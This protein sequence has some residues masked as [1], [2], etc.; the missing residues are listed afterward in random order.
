MAGRGGLLAALLTVGSLSDFV[1]RR[2]IIVA[3]LVI[4]AGAMLLI[5]TAQAPTTLILAR[6]L[7]GIA[8]GAAASTLGAMIM[9][10]CKVRGALINSAAPPLGPE[11]PLSIHA[12]GQPSGMPSS[13]IWSMVASGVQNQSYH[14]PC[15]SSWSNWLL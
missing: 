2:P 8:T 5:A 3:S 13:V 1:G 7:Q 9:D 6:F 4:E 11:F 15:E 12:Q 14:L 10:T